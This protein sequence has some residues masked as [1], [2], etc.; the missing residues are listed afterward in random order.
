MMLCF[1]ATPINS[2]EDCDKLQ[3]G[4]NTLERWAIDW[5]MTFNL[6]KCEFVRVTYKKNP[7]IAQFILYNNSIQEVT[8]TKYLGVTIDSKP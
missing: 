4:L 1:I 5:K 2:M 7:I 8:H 6:Q 3:Q